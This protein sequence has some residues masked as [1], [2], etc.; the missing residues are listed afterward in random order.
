[1]PFRWHVDLPGPVVWS[2]PMRKKRRSSGP[3]TTLLVWFI[4]K[5]FE[6]MFRGLAKLF[7]VRS[8]SNTERSVQ[9]L[10]VGWHP[11][12]GVWLYW[13]GQTWYDMNGRTVF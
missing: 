7:A 4:V 12:S 11:I 1:M 6:L 10:P 9:Q 5:P 8:R 13:N 2:R 3:L